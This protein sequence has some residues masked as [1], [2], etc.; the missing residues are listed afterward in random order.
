M[1]SGVYFVQDGLLDYVV[2][3]ITT[4]DKT[5]YE[6]NLINYV[7]VTVSDENGKDFVL[8]VYLTEG[9]KFNIGDTVIVDPYDKSF[10]NAWGN[11][12]EN[13]IQKIDVTKTPAQQDDQWVWGFSKN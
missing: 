12:V 6:G 8:T 3:K 5:F 1:K 11:A 9:Q 13:N 7:T 2:G 4:I 10:I